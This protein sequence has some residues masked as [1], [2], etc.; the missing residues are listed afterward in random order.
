MLRAG[1]EEA[2]FKMGAR[3]CKLATYRRRS[4]KPAQR[5]RF[6]RKSHTNESR[7][8]YFKDAPDRENRDLRSVYAKWDPGGEIGCD[9]NPLCGAGTAM[10]LLLLSEDGRN[11]DEE[12]TK[13]DGRRRT[14]DERWTEDGR[15]MTKLPSFI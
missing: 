7:K 3:T 6:P 10:M 8:P 4:P 2:R 5:N 11:E 13:H 9:S 12:Q 1:F 14:V 15:T